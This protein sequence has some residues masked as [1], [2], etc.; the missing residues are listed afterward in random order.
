MRMR[1][2]QLFEA[3]PGKASLAL[4]VGMCPIRGPIYQNTPRGGVL[5]H[6]PTQNKVTKCKKKQYKS[7]SAGLHPLCPSRRH[8]ELPHR[9]WLT[10]AL[11]LPNKKTQPNKFKP[12]I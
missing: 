1:P 10:T 9:G 7:K 11:G 3:M 12:I 6:P 8:G 5:A 2:Q 4:A